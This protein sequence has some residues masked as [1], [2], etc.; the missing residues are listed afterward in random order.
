MKTR[1]NYSK[2]PRILI[3]DFD[4][5]LLGV[6]NRNDCQVLNKLLRLL[7]RARQK[8]WRRVNI[9]RRQKQLR[10]R[11]PVDMYKVKR[12]SPITLASLLIGGPV[13]GERN[14]T[15][16]SQA[17]F[18]SCRGVFGSVNLSDDILN[19]SDFS[20]S[21]RETLTDAGTYI[22]RAMYAAWRV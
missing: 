1:R 17:F 13:C 7:V 12:F 6:F 14:P 21:G 11:P 9:K 4:R 22:R 3:Q 5:T 8:G 2:K 16:A 18:A 10:F 15:K 20:L 19:A